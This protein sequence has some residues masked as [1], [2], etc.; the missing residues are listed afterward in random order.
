MHKKVT[1]FL[2]HLALFTVFFWFG[3]IKLTGLSPAN[4]LVRELL[5]QIP[6]IKMWPFESFII[7]LGLVEML[8]AILLLFKKTT[9]IG[10]IFL[11]PH[12]FTT[13]LPLLLLPN[14]TWQSFLIPTLA[15]QYII[16]NIVIVALALSVV[17]ENKKG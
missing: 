17:L 4:D 3:A 2:A 16:K 12:M 15:G 7:V 1:F 5:I 9:K 14:L 10:I 8:I 11:I 13:M 6:I